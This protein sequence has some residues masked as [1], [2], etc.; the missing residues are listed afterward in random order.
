[1]DPMKKKKLSPHMV[2][3]Q[4][5]WGVNMWSLG[6]MWPTYTNSTYSCLIPLVKVH[7]QCSGNTA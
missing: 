3:P 7:G 2:W 5:G 1:M 4:C 6:I